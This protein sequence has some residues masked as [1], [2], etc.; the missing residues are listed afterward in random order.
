MNLLTKQKLRYDVE[1]NLT[2]IRRKG[3]GLNWDLGID[4]YTLLHIK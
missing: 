1:N 2:A 3:R 4:I